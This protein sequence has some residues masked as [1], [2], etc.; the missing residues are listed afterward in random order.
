LLPLRAHLSR[1]D[2]EQHEVSGRTRLLAIVSILAWAG[3]I[4]AGRLLA[5]LVP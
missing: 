5:Y 2:A 1:S 3:A 4:T